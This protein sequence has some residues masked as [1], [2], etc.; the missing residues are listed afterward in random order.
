MQQLAL[1]TKNFKYNFLIADKTYLTHEVMRIS[2]LRREYSSVTY[3]NYTL[4]LTFQLVDNALYAS[5]YQINSL[6]LIEK[7]SDKKRTI[8]LTYP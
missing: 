5:L 4:A 2:L 3:A 6:S 8:C 1:L 7:F